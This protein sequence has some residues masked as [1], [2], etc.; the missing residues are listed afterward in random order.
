MAARQLIPLIIFA[1]LASAAAERPAI[2]RPNFIFVI[3]DDLGW[4]D[5]SYNGATGWKTPHIDSLAEDGAHFDRLFVSAESAPTSA[6]LI[7]GLHPML[8]GVVSDTGGGQVLAGGITTIAEKLKDVG[9]TG[10]YFGAWRHGVNR[11][12]RPTDQGFDRFVGIC[13]DV[14]PAA[15]DVEFE[16]GDERRATNGSVANVLAKEA[17][18]FIDSNKDRPF[19]CMINHPA[20]ALDLTDLE[21]SI[22]TL[23]RHVGEIIQKITDLQLQENTVVF[24]LSDNGPAAI[25]G[26]FNGQMYGANGILHEGGLRSPGFVRWTGSIEAGLEINEICHAMDLHITAIDLGGGDLSQ[27]LEPPRVRWMQGMS[28]VPL[29]THGFVHRWP[30]RT[31]NE[32]AVDGLNFD[33]KTM[34]ATVRVSRWRAV[35]DLDWR[36][37]AIGENEETWELYDLK[38]DPT[39]AYDLA[40]FYP[41]VLG[42][43][44]SDFM[45]WFGRIN[46]HH[47]KPKRIEVGR[48]DWPQTRL[49]PEFAQIDDTALTWP[50]NV[51]EGGERRLSLVCRSAAAKSENLEISIGE[52]RE[53]WTLE[54]NPDWTEI[55]LGI[56][57]FNA[58]ESALKLSADLEIR[59]LII[60]LDS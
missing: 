32:V 34:R 9:Y 31:L 50:L 44:K 16:F 27:D 4:G 59:E 35:R 1:F 20:P 39:Q 40:G 6:A 23:D 54:L 52:S 56:L 60:S 45:Q 30:N 7:S 29:L 37:S 15:A 11:P 46:N 10:G 5:V 42:R 25:E 58:G 12:N 3:A 18:T 2:D 24:F 43:L 8:A 49:L 14:W 22:A 19:L 36:R 57:D 28:Y 17:L 13:R 48:D 26:R 47:F 55:E 51:V 41:E 33:Y 21:S 53:S 38:A